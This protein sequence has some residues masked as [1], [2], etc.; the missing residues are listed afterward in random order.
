M[1][2]IATFAA[3]LDADLLEAPDGSSKRSAQVIGVAID[4]A[5]GATPAGQRLMFVIVDHDGHGHLV[6][7]ANVTFKDDKVM[8]PKYG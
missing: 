7:A 8:P 4:D 6:S 3:A 1:P 5:D 2:A